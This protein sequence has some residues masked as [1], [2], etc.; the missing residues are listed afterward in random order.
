MTDKR[1]MKDILLSLFLGLSLSACA[2]NQLVKRDPAATAGADV[3]H[4]AM[5]T[6]M[7]VVDDSHHFISQE[8]VTRESLLASGKLQVSDL[9]EVETSI[10]WR[11]FFMQQGH[12]FGEEQVLIAALL[13][14]SSPDAPLEALQRK[15]HLLFEFCGL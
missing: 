14:R 13:R 8:M 9:D 5:R 11:N 3:C 10:A 2:T 7:E 6:L 1:M 15:Y 12:E 4:G